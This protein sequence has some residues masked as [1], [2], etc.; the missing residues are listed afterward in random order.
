MCQDGRNEPAKQIYVFGLEQRFVRIALTLATAVCPFLLNEC[1]R[2]LADEEGREFPDGSDLRIIAVDE[3]RAIMQAE[4][5]EGRLCLRC[6]IEVC[7]D[8]GVIVERMSARE[9]VTVAGLD[10]R[11][12]VD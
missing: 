11:H 3:A 5:V 9:A 4:I 8:E 1:G 7:N 10:G 12:A 2:I 6:A